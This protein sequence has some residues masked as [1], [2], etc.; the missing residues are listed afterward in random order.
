MTSKTDELILSIE[1]D[2]A[3]RLLELAER[4][5]KDKRIKPRQTGLISQKE[6][7]EELKVT[8]QTIKLWRNNGLKPYIPPIEGTKK[9]FFKISDVLAFLEVN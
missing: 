5:A 8:Y 7:E 3:S 9:V 6:L 2:S 4:M 1:R